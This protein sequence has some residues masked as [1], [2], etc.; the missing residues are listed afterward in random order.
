VTDAT[1]VPGRPPYG[2]KSRMVL[3]IVVTADT[4]PGSS[5]LHAIRAGHLE[6]RNRP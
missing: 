1:D 4:V 5:Q 6:P 2:L 3:E